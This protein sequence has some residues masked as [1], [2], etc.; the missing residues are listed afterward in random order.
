MCLSYF[1][2]DIQNTAFIKNIERI[3]EFPMQTA[4]SKTRQ[5]KKKS[6]QQTS[7]ELA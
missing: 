5:Y 6:Y 7:S 4:E 2:S 3:N 1:I